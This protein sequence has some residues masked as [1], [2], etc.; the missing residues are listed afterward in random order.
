MNEHGGEAPIVWASDAQAVTL[1]ERPLRL[2]RSPEWTAMVRSSAEYLPLA[3]DPRSV[4]AQA[5]A[6][7]ARPFNSDIACELSLAGVAMI[8]EHHRTSANG[9]DLLI[10]DL[11]TFL[12]GMARLREMGV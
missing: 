7:L 3:S 1:P 8:I 9:A 12:T 10:A 6:S 11:A 4:T 2:P 5:L